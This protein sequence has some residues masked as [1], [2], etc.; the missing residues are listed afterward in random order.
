MCKWQCCQESELQCPMYGRTLI[1]S[2]NYLTF[3]TSVIRVHIG[4]QMDK[5][6][7]VYTVIFIAAF[8]IISLAAALDIS[9]V[10][11]IVVATPGVTIL[12][13]ALYQLFRDNM[14]HE[15]SLFIRYREE[16]FETGC[17]S[18]MAEVT[19]DKHVGFCE[20]YTSRASEILIAL[21]KEAPTKKCI[22]YRNDLFEIRRKHALWITPEI[23]EQLQKFESVLSDIGANSG[24]SASMPYGEDRSKLIQEM[25]SQWQDLVGEKKHRHQQDTM[26][27]LEIIAWLQDVLGIKE[28]TLMRNNILESAIAKV[29]A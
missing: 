11:T 21:W 19:F 26:S 6:G 7:F 13:G 25:Y 9:D 8:V 27:V 2:Y 12:V 22:E 16:L 28:L 29:D 17:A 20:A 4:Q 18:H 5:R 10:A 1:I 14:A 15:R 23:V 3:I 24:I